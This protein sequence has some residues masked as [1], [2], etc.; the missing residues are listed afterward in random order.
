MRGAQTFACRAAVGYIL[1]SELRC[2]GAP[3]VRPIP[4]GSDRRRPPLS[5]PAGAV[6]CPSPAG[7]SL[8]VVPRCHADPPPALV[9]RHRGHPTSEVAVPARPLLLTGDPVLLDDL[10]RLA[11]SAGVETEVAHDVVAA[12]GSWAAAPLVLVGRGRRR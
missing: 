3:R 9:P 1:I 2:D 12:R 7:R 4:P 11:A 5:P 10:L 6:A 8:A